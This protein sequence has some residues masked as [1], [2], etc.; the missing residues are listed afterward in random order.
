LTSCDNFDYTRRLGYFSLLYALCHAFDAAYL[1]LWTTLG[2]GIVIPYASVAYAH[3]AL[4]YFPTT[5]LQYWLTQAYRCAD[6]GIMVVPTPALPPAPDEEQT[7]PFWP[8]YVRFS[9]FAL[10]VMVLKVLFWLDRV[11]LGHFSAVIFQLR[12]TF[13]MLIFRVRHSHL[14]CLS[15]AWLLLFVICQVDA[16][17]QASNKSLTSP[18]PIHSAMSLNPDSKTF[19]PSKSTGLRTDKFD[20]SFANVTNRKAKFEDDPEGGEVDK[21]AALDAEYK[22]KLAAME[23]ERQAL[24]EKLEAEREKD[25]EGDEKDDVPRSSDASTDMAAAFLTALKQLMGKDA[26]D[27]INTK[28]GPPLSGTV[29]STGLSLPAV[30]PRSERNFTASRVQVSRYNR[31]KTSE[32]RQKLRDRVCVKLEHTLKLTKWDEILDTWSDLDLATAVISLQTQLDCV[33]EFAVI[34]DIAYLCNVPHVTDMFDKSELSYCHNFV[35]LLTD[36]ASLDPEQVKSYQSLIN[37]QCGDTDVESSEWLRM[38]L[39]KSTES[40]LLVSVKQTMKSFKAHER[41]GLT[42]FKTVVD[43]IST[44]SFEFLQ[45]GTEGVIPW[46]GFVINLLSNL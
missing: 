33:T 25:S 11:V 39:E 32:A 8:T 43:K 15:C 30:A 42:F 38:V 6:E 12:W 27:E 17:S 14:F 7:V 29:L 21:F 45:A 31:G 3:H 5:T 2:I 24:L 36:Y 19:T 16:E 44:N 20:L 22:A 26:D 9:F 40:T 10:V 23:E 37:L 46:L 35:N 34:Y 1:L 4:F 13:T 18:P 41:G 28:Y